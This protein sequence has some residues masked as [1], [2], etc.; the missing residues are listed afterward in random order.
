[1]P[2][3][4]QDTQKKLFEAE[5]KIAKQEQESQKKLYE[6]EQETQK[7]LAKLGQESQKKLCEAEAKLL[8]LATKHQGNDLLKFELS[9]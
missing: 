2:T 4:L 3:L 5:N 6:A 7:K 8:N 1:V 9:I